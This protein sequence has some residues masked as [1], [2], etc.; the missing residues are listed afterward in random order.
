MK[1]ICVLI[2]MSS[3]IGCS[4]P[5]RVTPAVKIEF[6]IAE[7][8]PSENLT[9]ATIPELRETFYLHDKILLTNVD[10]ASA[11][12]I[13]LQDRPAVEVIFTE[14][15]R[16]KFAQVTEDNINKRLGILIDGALVTAPLIKAQVSVGKAIING[17]FTGE[18]ARRIADGIV[19]G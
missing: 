10:I 13:E 12:V 19:G 7:S 16:E 4:N 18:E 9:E 17:L 14:R 6:C 5:P 8:E 3:L 2:V 1:M 11:S 15:G